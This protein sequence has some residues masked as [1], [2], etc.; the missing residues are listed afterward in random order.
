MDGQ[1]RCASQNFGDRTSGSAADRTPFDVGRGARRSSSLGGRD[2][3][4]EHHRVLRH[5]AQNGVNYLV[6]LVSIFTYFGEDRQCCVSRELTKKFEENARGTLK[7]V[8][9]HF[10]AKGVKGEIVIVIAGKEK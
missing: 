9:E 1:A 10:S 3:H 2:R 7:E 4:S 6:K 8:L 5:R